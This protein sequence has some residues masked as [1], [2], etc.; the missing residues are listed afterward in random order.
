MTARETAMPFTAKHRF[1]PISPTKARPVAELIRGIWVDEALQKLRFTHKRAARL[2]EKVVQSAMA[3]AEEQAVDVTT[4]FVVDAR[5]DE[6]PT[7]RAWRPAARGMVSPIRKR[8]C[9]ITVVL[10]EGE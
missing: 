7:R 4:L 10:D 3:G 6:G 1:A 5:V 8:S 2:I 9:D